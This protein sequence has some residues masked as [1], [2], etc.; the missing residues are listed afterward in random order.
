[1]KSTP[2]LGDSLADATTD[3]PTDP[4]AARPDVA[5]FERLTQA[6]VGITTQSLD[7]LDGAVTVS[8][9]R[10]LRTLAGLGRAP[11]SAL[12]LALG[13]AASSVTRLADK[14]EAA[15]YLA[16]GSDA[17]SRS[18][19]TLEVTESGRA[20][21]TA[22]LARRHALIEAVLDTMSE[23]ER[24]QAAAAAE[25]FVRFAGDAVTAGA[26]GQRRVAL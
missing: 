6:L 3:S 23:T 16:R 7:V 22:V 8:Q 14:L 20:V 4:A 24:E 12:A 25:L 21:V 5:A 1:M 26:G 17:H 18:I 11:S 9:F 13:T 10:L 15:G 2:S 19:V